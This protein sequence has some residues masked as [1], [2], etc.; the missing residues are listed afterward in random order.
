MGAMKNEFM[1]LQEDRLSPEADY[2][3]AIEF[4]LTELDQ[5]IRDLFSLGMEPSEIT[6]SVAS[7]FNK[8]ASNE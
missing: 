2:T 6:K 7:S 5:V 3:L 8:A 1:K 4:C